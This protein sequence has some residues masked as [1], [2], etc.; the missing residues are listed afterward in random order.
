[1]QKFEYMLLNRMQ[2]DC[3]YYLNMG[4]R[5]PH[6]LWAGSEQAQIDEMKKLWNKLIIKPEWLTMEQIKEYERNM[7]VA[8]TN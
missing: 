4:N 2:S 1:M 8:L 3:E 6:R 7:V 5:N